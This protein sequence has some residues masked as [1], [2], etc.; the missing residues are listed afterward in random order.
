MN[1]LDCYPIQEDF[2]FKN[3]F[4]KLK[5]TVKHIGKEAKSGM[6]VLKDTKKKHFGIHDLQEYVNCY[7][8]LK[9][10]DEQ[11][12]PPGK[13]YGTCLCPSPSVPTGSP[14]RLRA[15]SSRCEA[16]KSA[17]FQE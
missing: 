6:K 1:S 14:P 16:P 15:W 3:T 2:S 12:K 9:V 4:K 17:V 13:Y 10:G 5:K 8:G 7:P 11:V